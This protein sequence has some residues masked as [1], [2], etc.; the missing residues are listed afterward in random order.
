[1]AQLL[2][3][4]VQIMEELLVGVLFLV[5]V[6]FMGRTF[7]KQYKTDSGCGS[8]NCGDVEAMDKKSRKLPDHFKR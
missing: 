7:W 8:C 3:R 6:L 4:S 1:M 2:V 5:A